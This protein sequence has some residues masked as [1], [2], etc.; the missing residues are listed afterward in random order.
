MINQFSDKAK[1]EFVEMF[2]EGRADVWFQ[3]IKLVQENLS[4]L[5]FCEALAKRFGMKGGL[6]EQEEFNKL[7]QNGTVLEYVERFEELK[8]VVLSR[9]PHLDEIY[10]ISSFISR[11]KGELKPMVRLMKPRTLLDAIEIAQYQEQI[12]EILVKKADSKKSHD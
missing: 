9:N 1:V 4:W 6:D 3:S 7:A 12:V 8:S 2:L 11:L 10:F 5:E